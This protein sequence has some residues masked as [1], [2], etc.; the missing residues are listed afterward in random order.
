MPIFEKNGRQVAFIHV[1]KAAGTSIEMMFKNAGW[2]MTFYSTTAGGYEVSSQHMRYSELKEKIPNLDD[3]PSF[4]IVREPL[5]RL[6]SEWAYQTNQMFSSDL[7]FNDF[8][9]HLDCSLKQT[10]IYWDNHWRPQV[11]FLDG[12]IDK[13]IK[14]ENMTESLLPFLGEKNII[15][16]PVVPHINKKKRVGKYDRGALAISSES[17]ER[18]L[19]VYE[20]DYTELG[21]PP[22]IQGKE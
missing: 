18:I 6:I 16:D 2:S 5:Q 17:I 11:D 8:V 12:P 22:V 13:V 15:L 21:Y 7:E 1:P 4:A 10:K 14:L 19:R 3:I 20:R 9:R